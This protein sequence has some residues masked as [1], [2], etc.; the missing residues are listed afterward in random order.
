MY[1]EEII[2]GYN[3]NKEQAIKEYDNAIKLNP[4]ECQAYWHIGG[5]I[6]IMTL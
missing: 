3:S 5:C 2:I 6:T 4:N 1:S